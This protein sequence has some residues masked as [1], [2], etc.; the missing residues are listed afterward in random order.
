LENAGTAFAIIHASSKFSQLPIVISEA[1]PEG[2]G[3]CSPPE[4]PED[5][6]R[7]GTLYPTYTAAAMKGLLDLAKREQVDLAGFLT[8]AFEFEDQPYFSSHRALSTN[9]V[10]KPELNFFRMAGLLGGQR[11]AAMSSGAVPVQEIVESG[12]RQQPDV[13]AIATRKSN[14]AVV[15]VWNYQ[16]DE[17]PGPGAPVQVSVSGIPRSV[18]R[19]LVQQFRIDEHHSNAFTAWKEMGSPQ[20]PDAEQYAKLQAAGQLQLKGSPTWATAEHGRV[21][22]HLELPR[23]SV[24]LLR[25]SWTATE[26]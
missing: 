17:I 9:G 7:D 15:M 5:T 14:S 10:D 22:V 13:D 2:C 19:V 12:V 21:N 4:H 23:E 20:H 11:V 25:V 26:N 24:A 1:D 8:W 18:H 6:Y 16:D 3:A